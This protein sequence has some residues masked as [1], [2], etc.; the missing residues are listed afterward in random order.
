MG[1]RH[2]PDRDAVFVKKPVGD[3][4]P[5]FPAVFPFDL[6]LHR[7]GYRFS[8]ICILHKPLKTLFVVFRQQGAGIDVQK[9]L[10]GVAGIFAHDV[11]DADIAHFFEIHFKNPRRRGLN[12]MPVPGFTFL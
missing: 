3:D 6:V 7:R 10:A 11:I 4:D 2:G 1:H 12:Q 5:Y 8:R 9:F